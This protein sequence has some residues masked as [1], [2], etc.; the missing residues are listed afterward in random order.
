MGKAHLNILRFMD[1]LYEDSIEK[2][3]DGLWNV[4]LIGPC[5]LN[6]DEWALCTR[7]HNTIDGHTGALRLQRLI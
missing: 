5:T 2:V 4:R 7:Y 3:D 1:E 6:D